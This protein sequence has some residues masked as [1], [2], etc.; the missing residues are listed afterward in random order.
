MVQALGAG[1]S[2]Q[3]DLTDLTKK[4]KSSKHGLSNTRRRCRM[5]CIACRNRKVRCDVE[6]GSSPCTNCRLDQEACIVQ[7]KVRQRLV[8][9]VADAPIVCKLLR[10]ADE[11]IISKIAYQQS[12]NLSTP[13]GIAAWSALQKSSHQSKELPT[14]ANSQGLGNTHVATPDLEDV[15]TVEDEFEAV[16]QSP[17]VSV[18]DGL[19]D[20]NTTCTYYVSMANS[21]LTTTH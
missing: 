6:Q 11:D 9:P 14:I 12:F 10:K 21:E 3:P 4:R 1:T 13:E 16:I 18:Q 15:P 8:S 19:G 17:R 7:N 5:A 20:K 2:S